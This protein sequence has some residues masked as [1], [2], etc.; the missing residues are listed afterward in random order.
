M[1]YVHFIKELSVQEEFL[2]CNPLH[3]PLLHSEVQWRK[4]SPSSTESNMED[5]KWVAMLAYLSDIFD[6]INTLN[7]FLQGKERHVFL[8]HDQVF[9]FRKKLD[10]WCACVDRGSVEM[11][12]T[13]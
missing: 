12:P 10:L 2:F 13:L 9:A 5:A 6:R 3:Q 4:S 7:T 1:V 11:F 8:V